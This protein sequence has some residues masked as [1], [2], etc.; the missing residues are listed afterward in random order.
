MNERTRN[1]SPTGTE[2]I[3]SFRLPWRGVVVVLALLMG[4]FLP[5]SVGAA[6]TDGARTRACS[7][8]QAALARVG[9]RGAAAQALSSRM[10]RLG[11]TTSGPTTTS[12]S[13]PTSTTV[14]PGT[15]VPGGS[16][17]SVAGGP[18]TSSVF[19][20][21]TVPG[22]STTSSSVFPGPGHTAPPTLVFPTTTTVPGGSTVPSS[23]T[24]IFPSPPTTAPPGP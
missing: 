2:G 3:R 12:S 9:D 5:M 19:P 11:C 4:W 16:P 10:Q 22:G 1:S 14:V 17:T 13:G 18:P 8:L 20:G 24:T 7:R 15:S 6:Q 21:T 23:S